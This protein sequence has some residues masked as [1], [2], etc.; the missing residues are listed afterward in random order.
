MK[1]A[2]GLQSG[3]TIDIALAVSDTTIQIYV[4]GKRFAQVTENRSTGATH[5]TL[6]LNG[7]SGALHTESLR[8]Y[9]VR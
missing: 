9:A 1:V 3:S 5:P 7:K 2:P 6:Y 4:D 8:Y